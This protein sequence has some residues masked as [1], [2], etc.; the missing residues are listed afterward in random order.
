MVDSRIFV[1]DSIKIGD[2]VKIAL[3]LT[4]PESKYIEGIVKVVLSKKRLEENEIEVEL[5]SGYIG[6]VK[7]IIDKST[8]ARREQRII[9]RENETVEKKETFGFDVKNNRKNSE[10]K[11]I[12][13]TAVVSLMNT[14]GGYVYIGVHDSGIVRGLDIDYSIITGGGN[15]DKLEQQIRDALNKYFD[16]YVIVSNC[17][18]ILFPNVFGHEICEIEVRPSP[19]PIFFKR[20]SHVVSID[21]NN[22]PRKFD[23]F[24]IRDGNG[25]KLLETH[26][27]FLLHWKVRF[28]TS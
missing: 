24:Y 11:K 3:T 23:D 8:P 13:A 5:I 28:Q 4:Q 17:I 9:K 2:T 19:E 7:E 21:G 18:T 1:R 22:V 16:D 12:V 15:N 27:E 6:R 10:M 20:T 25:K 26:H 14:Y